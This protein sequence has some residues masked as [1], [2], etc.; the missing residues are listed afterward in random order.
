MAYFNHA[1]Q[2]M[3][4]GTDGFTTT[5]GLSSSAFTPENR[6]GQFTFVDP[7][8]WVT[9]ADL[10][11]PTTTSCPLVLI[12]T[13][14]HPNDKIGKFHG[15]YSET[16]KSK[17]INPKYVS[18]FYV[19]DDCPAQQ[20]QITVGAN[21]NN[22]DNDGPC[23]A[24]SGTVVNKTFLCGE[25]YD[26]RLDIK[27]SPAL[28]FLTR[29]DYYTTS[30]YTG[31]CPDDVIAPVAVNPLIVY[32]KWAYDL[33][34][35]PLINPF[36]QVAVTYSTDGGTTW[37]ALAAINPTLGPNYNPNASVENLLPY[38]LGGT[39][40]PANATPEDTLAGLIITGAYEDTRFG[41]CTFYP[42]DSII[43]FLEPVKL[44]ASE[45]DN[46]GDPCTF[47]GVCVYNSC[48]ALQLKGTG[49]NVIRD[50]I[51]TEGYMQ[52]PFYTGQDLRIREITNGTDVY[53]AISRTSFY[54]RYYIQHNVPRFNNPTGTFDNDQY[55]LEIVTDGRDTDFE[56]FV[57]AWLEN[58]GS[59]C[60]VLTEYTCP[61]YCTPVAPE[62]PVLP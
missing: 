42:N 51:L 20:A 44:Y 60:T 54:T 2:K 30:A 29:N 34:N 39:A 6:A 53:D 5:G 56:D 13:S 50:L 21:Q 19:V 9:P 46:N 17:T 3:F 14:I 45:V 48:D 58:A 25:N 55:L 15:G 4:V 61:D 49:E 18:S 35:S 22:W 59:G 41:D 12:S 26:L 11:G 52:Q 24:N 43:A 47:G 10:A 1:F 37:E 8:T 62:T 57:T 7:K 36:I 31:C 23:N 32:S 40:L 27:G 16:V 33:L 38:V 28:R